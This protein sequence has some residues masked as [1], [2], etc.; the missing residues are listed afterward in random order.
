MSGESTEILSNYSTQAKIKTNSTQ[1][2]RTTACQVLTNRSNKFTQQSLAYESQRKC[3]TKSLIWA[4][5]W[6]LEMAR[7]VVFAS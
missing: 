1:L 4:A 6:Q 2:A 5:A 3:F 7:K